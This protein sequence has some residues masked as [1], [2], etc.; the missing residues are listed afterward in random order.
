[1]TA[2]V[3]VI[4]AGCA[5]LSAAVRLAD[6][7]LRVVVVEQ[8]P[9]LGGRTAAFT[10]RE[11]GERVD[12]G[13]HALFGCYHETYAYLRRIGTAQLATPAPR[14]QLT[15]TDGPGRAY[16]L[17][18]PSWPPPWHLVGGLLRWPALSWPDRV[19]A[20]RVARVI[21][22]ARSQGAAAVVSGVPADQTVSEW[23]HAR[24]QS[25]RL[26]DWL[27]HPL[28]IAALNQSPDVASA[29]MFVRVLADLFGPDPAD[30]AI[31][32]PSVPLDEL[33]A[34]PAVKIIEGA[35]GAVLMKSAAT[36]SV[37]VSG[38]RVIAVRAGDQ[39]IT[40]T[41]VVSAV[42]WYAFASL[43]DEMPAPVAAVATAASHLAAS[44]IVT[45]N[46]WYDRAVLLPPIDRFV[47]FVGSPLHWAFDKSA[48]FGAAAG[49]IS[50]VSSGAS[51]L[52]ADDNATL[53]ALATR[54]MARLVPAAAS[55]QCLRA[56]VVREP[57]ASFSTAPGG[58]ARP[59]VQTSLGGFH[60]AGDWTDT[61]LPA[62]I[63]GAVVSGHRAAAAVLE[64]RTRAARASA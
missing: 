22:R 1:M 14:L 38:A 48:I 36:V 18:C 29:S 58:P 20:G 49:H 35:G 21:L 32:L 54:E 37:D 63:E 25:A 41:D 19:R 42:P 39:V 9:R 40:T 10:D 33:F 27:W 17:T 34:A 60:L 62:T 2:D 6:A 46:L 24:G 23:L 26:I 59:G 11:T 53:T 15:M 16:A 31:A 55:A 57:R 56:V 3:V 4:G 12:N 5:G 52:V 64:A 7:G 8:A 30:A 44:P 50:I 13:Q 51:A 47:G 45:V 61:G 43:W 28:A